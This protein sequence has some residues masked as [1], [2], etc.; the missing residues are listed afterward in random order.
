MAPA[1]W[2]GCVK[3]TK[4]DSTSKKGRPALWRC[5]RKEAAIL[6]NVGQSERQAILSAAS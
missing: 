4:A 3:P 5:D 1:F 2:N 6:I